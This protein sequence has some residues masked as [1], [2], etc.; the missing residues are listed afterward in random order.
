MQ[1]LLYCFL[2]RKWE[3]D[4]G[5]LE[6][7]L[8]YFIDTKYP[9]Q[10]FL[11]PEGTDFCEKTKARSDN[12][13]EKN[14]LPKYEYVLHPRTT[15]FNYLVQK[16]RGKIVDYVYDVTI[17][18]PV[19]LCYGEIDLLKGDFP[20]EVH[21]YFKKYRI[22]DLPVEDEA[23]GKWCCDRFEEKEKRL[24]NFYRDLKFTGPK[25]E[26]NVTNR[27]QEDHA[28][29]TNYISL[30]FWVSF[31]LYSFYLVSSS[32]LVMV[33]TLI[34]VVAHAVLSYYRGM[35]ALFLDFHDKQKCK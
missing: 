11:F 34:V 15:G 7:Y 8:D 35:D 29:V 9:L 21:L 32:T 31:V 14:G 5:Y 17:G 2:Q 6:R 20:D 3:V 28:S 19:N 18:F 27:L 25:A 16:T 30:I 24:K 22:K 33:Y 4:R 12:F 26:Q 10:F 23:L 1:Y 13:A